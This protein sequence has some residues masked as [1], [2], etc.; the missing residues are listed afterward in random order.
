M[1]REIDVRDFTV[2]RVDPARAET[3]RARATEASERMRGSHRVVIRKFDATTGNPAVVASEAAPAGSGDY[4]M[5]A[6]DH[7]QAISPVLG[8]VSQAPE[9]TTDAQVLE[10]SSGAHAVNLQQLYK[11]IPVFQA[12][13]TVRFVPDGAIDDTVGSTISVTGEVAVNPAVSVQEAV[14]AAARH[15]AEPAADEQGAVDPFGEPLNPPRVDLTGFVPRV[16]ASFANTA[17]RSTVLEAGPFGAEI[18]ASLI[19]FP[20][21]DG[22]VLGWTSILT[23]PRH[24]GQ[25]YTIVSA[26]TGQILYCHQMVQFVAAAGNVYRVDGGSAR[27]MTSFPRPVNDYGLPMPAQAQENWRWCH[28]CQG[29]FFAGNPGSHC[30]AGGAHDNAGSF[31]YVLVPDS[32]LYPGQA[33]W[34]WCNKCQGLF[35]GDN[36]GSRCPA[37]GAHQNAGSF[38]YSLLSQNAL[39]PGQHGW[40]WCH[41][42]QGLF[43]GDLP[44]AVCPAGGA[45]QNAGSFDYALLSAASGLPAPFPDTW[46]TA[47]ATVGNSTN[48]HLDVAGAS[49]TGAVQGGLLTFNPASATGD[50]QKVLN[51]FYYCCYMHDFAYLL[52][53]REASRN[54]QTNNLGRGGLAGDAVDARSFPGA[55]FGTANMSRIG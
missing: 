55:V 12:A 44:G 10:T 53:F 14:L 46:V 21:N 38:N 32:P 15:V 48:A 39:A 37:G 40:R 22:L 17:E 45:H 52:G 27:Q 20:V 19:W 36:P 50:D 24:E 31:N 43:F 35:F 42:C 6:L 4:V 9:F 29:L 28:K 33:G 11:G 3:L 1:S 30:P 16:R 47:S 8:L 5:R 13:V 23:M 41:K 34:R 26:E 54:F 25:Y 18:L 49:L 2:N 51:I 7:V